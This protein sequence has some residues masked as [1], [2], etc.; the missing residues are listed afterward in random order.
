MRKSLL[1]V[2]MFGLI[3]G[4]SYAQVPGR[5]GPGAG[6]PPD[7]SHMPQAMIDACKDKS[8]GDPC[9]VKTPMGDKSGQCTTKNNQLICLPADFPDRT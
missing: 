2:M 7:M 8:E 1:T 6:G 4:I 3:L 5:D 9:Q